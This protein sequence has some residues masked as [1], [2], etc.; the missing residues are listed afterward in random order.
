MLFD[1]DQ[2]L[3]R[4]GDRQAVVAAM[5]G[6]LVKLLGRDV[7]IYPAPEAEPQVFPS[8]Q[9]PAA[10]LL[11]EDERTVAIWAMKNNKHA[12]A[13]TDTFSKAQCLYLA[14]RVGERVYGACLLYTSFRRC[15]R[16]RAPDR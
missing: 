1:T 11:T 14:I 12:G 5:A 9:K 3:A 6:Q 16:C 13:T 4:A 2:L 10:D 7:V 15:A 8:G